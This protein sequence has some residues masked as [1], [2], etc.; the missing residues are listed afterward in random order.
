MQIG[1]FYILKER[2]GKRVKA[3]RVIEVDD[4][5]TFKIR[6]HNDSIFIGAPVVSQK[7]ELITVAAK[8]VVEEKRRFSKFAKKTLQAIRSNSVVRDR[9]YFQDFLKRGSLKAFVNLGYFDLQEKTNSL[10]IPVSFAIAYA[11]LLNLIK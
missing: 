9:I 4:S 2:R 1:A 3:L 7:E 8:F 6:T 10:E 11:K 5:A